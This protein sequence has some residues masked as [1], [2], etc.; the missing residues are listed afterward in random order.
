MIR[1]KKDQ[2]NQDLVL[3]TLQNAF[4]RDR[5]KTNVH[6]ISH[7]GLL[8]VT[9]QRTRAPLS[10]VMEQECE[11]CHGRGRIEKQNPVVR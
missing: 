6:G 5:V 9:R 3:Q 11:V 10:D 2:N 7:L 8:E 4:K 1:A